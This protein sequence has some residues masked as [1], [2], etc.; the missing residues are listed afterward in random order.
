MGYTDGLTEARSPD[1]ELFTRNRLLTLL[2]NPPYSAGALLDKVRSS[3]FH[4]IGSAPRDDDVTMIAVQ[5]TAP[6]T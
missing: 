3:L 6:Q 1:G 2:T 5:R 4:F